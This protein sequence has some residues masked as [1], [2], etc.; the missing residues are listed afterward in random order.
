MIDASLRRRVQAGET[1]LGCF[2][3]LGSPMAAELCGHAGYDWLIVDLEHGATTEATL[4]AMLHAVA[5]TPAEAVVRVEEATRLRIGRA[6]DFGAR[7]LMVPRIDTVEQ[8]ERAASYVRYQPAGARG[9]ALP[10]RGAGYGTLGHAGVATAHD[11]ICLFVQIE[12]GAALEAAPEIAAVEGVDVLFIG[13]ADLSHALGTPGDIT[14]AAYREAVSFVGAAAASAGKAAGVLLW[15]LEELPMYIEAGYRAF[16]LGS[17]GG[18]VA[19]AARGL[20]ADFR[21]RLAQAG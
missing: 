2:L 16:A 17:D 3:N 19:A 15:S 7:A 10:T 6:L 13:P 21:G 5:A 1:T 14:S 9:V 11:D 8:V 18:F 20:V 4:L 12:S